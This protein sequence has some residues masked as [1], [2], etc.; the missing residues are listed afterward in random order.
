MK[1]HSAYNRGQS[2]TGKNEKRKDYKNEKVI[3]PLLLP[4]FH[5]L[6]LCRLQQVFFLAFRRHG[7]GG[8]AGEGKEEI[9]RK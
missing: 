4:C 8:V 7:A 9:A 6:L 3:R 5:K 1:I 2:G